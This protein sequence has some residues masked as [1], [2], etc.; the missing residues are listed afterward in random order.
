MSVD[1]LSVRQSTDRPSSPRQFFERIYGE[2]K[3]DSKK[4]SSN[5]EFQQSNSSQL[6]VDL[7]KSGLVPVPGLMMI[8][9]YQNYGYSQHFAEQTFATGFSAF[10][11]YLRFDLNAFRG[12]HPWLFISVPRSWPVPTP[13]AKSPNH[14][15]NI[16]LISVELKSS[17]S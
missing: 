7:N 2:S 16:G 5:G 14:N 9:Y 4:E 6:P 1:K 8:P 12:V 13:T 17:S 3:S 15:K 11:K 10:R